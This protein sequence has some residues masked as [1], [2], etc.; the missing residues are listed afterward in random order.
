MRQLGL[1]KG[2]RVHGNGRVLTCIARG[3]PKGPEPSRGVQNVPRWK[4]EE[5]LS[6]C[7]AKYH[8]ALLCQVE[9]PER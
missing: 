8:G 4:L 1:S 2:K 6:T 5:L 3:L 7:L 9:A